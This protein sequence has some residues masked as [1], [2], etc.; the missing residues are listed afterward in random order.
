MIK[1]GRLLKRSRDVKVL[2]LIMIGLILSIVVLIALLQRHRGAAPHNHRHTV[3]VKITVI[4]RGSV[5]ELL[6][7]DAP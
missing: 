6:E 4:Y 5:V 1:S 3:I 2:L 7:Q